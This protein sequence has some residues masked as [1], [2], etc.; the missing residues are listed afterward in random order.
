MER[1]SDVGL[2]SVE[3]EP[4]S[5]GQSGLFIQREVDG[6]GEN[7]GADGGSRHDLDSASAVSLR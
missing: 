6:E 7:E 5:C 3:E 1:Y 2:V 4:Q